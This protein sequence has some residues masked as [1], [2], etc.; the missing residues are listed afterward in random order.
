MEVEHVLERLQ[1]VRRNGSGWKALCPAHDDHTPSL[2][3]SNGDGAILIKCFAGCE[4]ED[5]VSSM[6]L[7]MADLFSGTSGNPSRNTGEREPT[8]TTALP[9]IAETEIDRMHQALTDK[10]RQY[11]IERRYLTDEVIDRYQ[12]GFTEKWGDRRISIPVLDENRLCVNVRCWLPEVYRT[13]KSAKILPWA[14]GYGSPSTLFP[15]D[16]LE[17]DEL[18]NPAGG[19][20]ALALVSAGIPAF[21]ATCGEGTWPDDLSEPLQGKT[22]IVLP[23]NDVAPPHPYTSS[24]FSCTSPLSRFIAWAKN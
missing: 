20:D 8:R 12:L 23:D 19:L 17:H 1:G 9:P 6:G 13:V 21:T 3:V 5:V 18:V 24:F 22:V 15:L 11:L 4:T 10:Q 14:D 16:Q 2:S 7:T